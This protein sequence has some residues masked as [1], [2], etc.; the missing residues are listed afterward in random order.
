MSN[1]QAWTLYQIV[2]S[3]CVYARWT[4]RY[5]CYDSLN[6]FDV[7]HGEIVISRVLA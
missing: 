4:V 5:H 2:I 3:I 1:V 7:D 6:A